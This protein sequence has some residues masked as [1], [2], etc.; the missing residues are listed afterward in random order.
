MKLSLEWITSY[1]ENVTLPDPEALALKLTM[2]T[3]EVEG[4]E[5]LVRYHKNVVIGKILTCEAHAE[6][7][8]D[9]PL[10]IITIDV[11]NGRTLS[12]ICSAANVATGI[13]TAVAL[14]G[15]ELAGGIV[16]TEEERHGQKCEAM[17][18][19]LKEIGWGDFHYG[20][21]EFPQNL[22]PGTP[23]SDLVPDDDYLIEF[24]NKSLTHRADLWG[25]YGFARELAAILHGTLKPLDTTDL[26]Q[27]DQLPALDI[28]VDDDPEGCRGYSGIRLENLSTAP[29]PALLQARL[30]ATGNRPINVL[31]DLTNYL[32]WELAQPMHSFDGRKV[33]KLH[34]GPF[35]SKGTF[36]TLDDQER[37]M[38]PTDLMIYNEGTPV[39]IAGVMGGQNSQV[40]DDTT[41]L[42]LESANFFPARI[43]RTA[44]RL[45]LRTDSSMRFEKN[46]PI[47]NMEL[48]LCRYVKLLQDAGQDVKVVSK[49]TTIIPRP[50]EAA[51]ITLAPGYIRG[52]VGMDIS[53]EQINSIL[54]SLQFNI[55]PQSDGGCVVTAPLFRTD[56][57]IAQDLVEEVARVYGYDNIVP[58][59]PTV[60]Q[61]PLKHLV[62]HD[63]LQIARKLMASSHNF[64]EVH[65]YS[66]FDDQWLKEIGGNPEATLRIANPCA[67]NLA[68]LRTSL[69]PN[70]LAFIN[71]N[72][73]HNDVL[74]LFE[75]GKV[76]FPVGEKD[77]AEHDNICGVL[78]QTNK[79]GKLADLFAKG[80]GIVSS[81]MDNCARGE[82][83]QFVP[84]TADS[85]W[86]WVQ[87]TICLDIKG[88]DGKLFG[89]LGHL[90]GSQLATFGKGSQ[91]VWFELN[92]AAMSGPI[93]PN[94]KFTAPSNVPGSWLD[95]TVLFPKDKPYGEFES[96]VKKFEN[97]LTK[98]WQ[99][100]GLYDG[101]GLPEGMVSYSIRYWLGR[102]DRT[103][104]GDEITEFHQKLLEHIEKNGLKLR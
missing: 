54:E 69:L 13:V 68:R 103:I 87:P 70:L 12:T 19:S 55:A 46:Q 76:F 33:S 75:A 93:Y 35:G 27:F 37:Q 101:K 18:C 16:V 4:V 71:A 62:E 88:A 29:S 94:V 95:F 51:K 43:R 66:W 82:K 44:L 73:R 6:N 72:R 60:A 86:P 47:I 96:I 59:M 42:W 74:R 79:N 90:A 102:A 45:A 39:A 23:L 97:T 80:K 8:A 98:G 31:V 78:Y 11:G 104:S 85:Q 53:E 89:R 1:L 99:L 48:A 10:H 25:H 3:A 30:A 9:H 41:S 24:D 34:V 20:I 15:A 61:A 58:N 38:I 2:A 26:H 40:F 77:W 63:R 65:S 64:N 91:I 67:Q 56:I 49:M 52:K 50:V 92:L 5:H 21:I 81:I 28:S 17:C 84:A 83:F 14:P 22:V 32:L 36:M 100:L 57:G 7:S